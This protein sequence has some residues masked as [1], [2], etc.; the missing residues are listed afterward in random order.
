MFCDQLHDQD[1]VY[2][3]ITSTSTI[4]PPTKIYPLQQDRNFPK[5]HA[6]LSTERLHGQDPQCP[7]IRTISTPHLT[8]IA[9]NATG[10]NIPRCMESK[11]PCHI[12]SNINYEASEATG[13]GHQVWEGLPFI[14]AADQSLYIILQQ[15]LALCSGE[16][17]KVVVTV[18]GWAIKEAACWELRA[19]RPGCQLMS[20]GLWQRKYLGRRHMRDMIH[21]M[22][23]YTQDLSIVAAN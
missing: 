4:F 21:I 14:V 23:W 22:A 9:I 1:T 17:V 8:V 18:M 2:G 13:G 6:R 15:W 7:L 5:P 16:R 3:D 11:A 10:M 12:V 19:I 20:I